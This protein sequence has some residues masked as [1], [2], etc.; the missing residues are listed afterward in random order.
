MIASAGS[1]TRAA[2][3]LFQNTAVN[4]VK[5]LAGV[6]G[7]GGPSLTGGGLVPRGPAFLESQAV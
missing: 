4:C 3:I 1:G 6:N 7:E 2:L 5:S